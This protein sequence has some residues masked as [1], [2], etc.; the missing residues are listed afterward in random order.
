MLHMLALK[1][2]SVCLVLILSGMSERFLD[3]LSTV[4]Y[5]LTASEEGPRALKL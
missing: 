3:Q 1:L 5:R 2:T 4:T